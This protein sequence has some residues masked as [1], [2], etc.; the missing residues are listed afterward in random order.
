MDKDNYWS[1]MLNRR[2]SRRTA[3]VAGG[4]GAV[5]AA[6]TACSGDK[7]GGASGGSGAT[8]SFNAGRPQ[9]GESVTDLRER[10]HGKH[11]KELPGQKDGPRYGGTYHVSDN[12]PV[13]WDLTSAGASPLAS[14][15]YFHN[16]LISFEMGD[17]AENANLWN[18]EACLAQKWERP[19]PDSMTIRLQPGVKWQNIP[20]VNGRPLTAEDVVYALTAYKKAPVQAPIYR[21]VDKITAPDN[22]TV[23]LTFTS[24][25]AYFER[26]QSQPI[27]LIFSKEQAESS[28]G[29]AKR[30]VGT[31]AFIFDQGQDR[32]GYT[33]HKNPDY[34]RKDPRSGQQLPYIDKIEATYF[35][36][37]QSSLAAFR[38]KKLDGI[39]PQ[40]RVTWASVFDTNPDVVSQ[41]TTPPPSFQ[42]FIP[43]R[44]D[45]AP[46]SDARVRRAMSLAVDRD[47][48]IKGTAGGLAGYGYGQDWSFWEQEWPW[49]IG[50]LGS[51]M[52]FDVQQ[53]KQLMKAAGFEN[54][55][56]RKAQFLLGQ[57]A[58]INF[59]VWNLVA[60]YWRRNLGLETEINA[61][62]DSAVWQ[63]AYFTANFDDLMG[64]GFVGPSVEPDAYSYDP[65]NSKSP[66]NY[67][68]VNDATLDDLTVKQGQALD[69]NTR[70]GL[71]KQIMDR[72]LDQMYRIWTIT[73]YKISVRYPHVFNVIDTIHAWMNPGWGSKGR[74]LI[75]FRS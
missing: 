58:G 23:T 65:L 9:D 15:A 55:I 13:T 22:Q 39:W 40:D 42:P 12:V 36:D 32:V 31:G 57:T 26:M 20:P 18:L 62:Q 50:Q 19:S 53:A 21:A 14:W 64:V 35:A 4:A 48:I 72:D 16:P 69:V 63:R 11:L 60:D 3:L 51:Y 52:K 73:P 10:Y 59:D 66:K 54:G 61:P 30:P 1:R 45:K 46:W 24:P 8:S 47:A 34:W 68:H 6:I 38:D 5:A 75:W 29:M 27:N 41:M 44:V 28:E 56:G 37:P 33:A 67:F 43:I 7:D 49:D 70:R 71:L 2:L 74:E 17:F 25:A